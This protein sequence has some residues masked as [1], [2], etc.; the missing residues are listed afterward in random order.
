MSE[1]KI[2]DTVIYRPCFGSGQKR[3]AEV[4]G[5]ELSQEPREKYGDSVNS[6]SREDV[7]NN[8]LKFNFGDSWCY[9]DQI[10]LEDMA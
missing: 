4:Q 1:I 6:V 10:C 5:M 3:S 7:E 9:S 2:G 8:L